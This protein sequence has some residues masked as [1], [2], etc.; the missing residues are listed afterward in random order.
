MTI[1]A[2]VAE[3][4]YLA[5]LGARVR[6]RRKALGL[7]RKAVAT[8]CGVHAQYIGQIERGRANPT[9]LLAARLSR[10]LGVELMLLEADAG[11]A[12]IGRAVPDGL[13]SEKPGL[14]D[15]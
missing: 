13:T 1:R 6:Y 2:T 14:S 3:A 15:R 11:E 12:V 4:A 7:T 8:L 10:V 9:V 5:E